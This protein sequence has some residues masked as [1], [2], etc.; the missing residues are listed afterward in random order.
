MFRTCHLNRGTIFHILTTDFIIHNSR[1]ESFKLFLSWIV[2][3]ITPLK[4]T[5]HLL[6]LFNS[7]INLFLTA[8]ILCTV[9]SSCLFYIITTFTLQCFTP[10][11]FRCTVIYFGRKNL[12][13]NSHLTF[14]TLV[15]DAKWVVPFQGMAIQNDSPNWWH[16]WFLFKTI[17]FK[18]FYF[19]Y[20]I[21]IRDMSSLLF[22]I[23]PLS[24][25]LDEIENTRT[26]HRLV[27]IN[28][29][30]AIFFRINYVHSK[31]PTSPLDSKSSPK[32]AIDRFFRKLE[33]RHHLYQYI[34]DRHWSI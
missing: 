23:T 29:S 30:H 5:I 34:I 27:V 33:V 19:D 1:S 2:T 4:T 8:R 13:V 26:V 31:M 28:K 3:P 16:S 25:R 12:I 20:I 6:K 15:S 7:S 14:G 21:Y 10:S 9:L 22:V 18:G 32:L 17:Q 11:Q 24:E